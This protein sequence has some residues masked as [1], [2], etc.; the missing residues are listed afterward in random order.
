MSDNIKRKNETYKNIAEH[1]ND[2]ADAFRAIPSTLNM[3][4]MRTLFISYDLPVVLMKGREESGLVLLGQSA[5]LG[6]VL[7]VADLPQAQ[8]LQGRVLDVVNLPREHWQDQ[9]VVKAQVDFQEQPESGESER[10]HSRTHLCVSVIREIP[11][12]RLISTAPTS[13]SAPG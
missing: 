7:E 1:E 12:S 6:G 4:T 13:S 9:V 3:V 2:V 5:D 8:R 10:V 11:R